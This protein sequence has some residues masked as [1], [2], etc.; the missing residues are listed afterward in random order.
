MDKK[1]KVDKFLSILNDHID[2]RASD[3]IP[4]D[5]YDSYAGIGSWGSGQELEKALYDLFDIPY[6]K[7]EE[8]EEEEEDDE[9][10]IEKW[11]RENGDS[12]WIF[13]IDMG[14]H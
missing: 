2:N 1:E 13:D 7:E 4:K 10:I 12:D 6:E 11:D 9:D 3:M 8:E 5:C 14:D